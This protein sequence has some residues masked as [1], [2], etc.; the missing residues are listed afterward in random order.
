MAVFAVAGSEHRPDGAA[1]GIGGMSDFSRELARLMDERSTGVR[2]LARDVYVNAGHVSNLRSGRARPSDKLVALLDDHLNANNS[3]RDAWKRDQTQRAGQAGAAAEGVIDVLARV[4]NLSR[5]VDPQVMQ[6]LQGNIAHTITQYER[7]D[8]ASLVPIL[9][10][11]RAWADRLLAESNR[12]GQ[13]QQ[14][15]EIAG[16]TSGVLGYVSVGRGDFPL[17]RAYCLEAFQLAS[18]AQASTLQAWA[19]GMQSFCEYYAG[20]YDDALR[21]AEDGLSYARSG[22]Q[23]VRLTINGIARARGKLGDAQGVYRAVGQAYDLMARN[24]VP[25]GMPSSI[26]LESYSAAQTAS[27]AATAYVAL[28]MTGKVQHFIELALPDISAAESPWSRSLVMI[29]L[30]M[31]HVRSADGQGGDLD[32]AATLVLDA[33]AI[34]ANRPV[35]SVTQRTS[36]FARDAT[37]RWGTVRQVSAVRDVAALE[38]H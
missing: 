13:R 22:P 3:L 28:G 32:Q 1:D 10:K 4:Q 8:H 30:A 5:A 29:D 26:S 34:S 9:V 38:A 6:R 12:P 31:S 24:D 35:I 16:A 37:Q 11:Q 18:L 2:Q 33:L 19:R 36:E 23:S 14:L 15:F 17:A 25:G 21:L 20:H 27:N 7:L